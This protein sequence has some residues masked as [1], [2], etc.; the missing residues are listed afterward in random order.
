MKKIALLRVVFAGALFLVA[1]SA[2]A[3]MAMKSE[4]GWFDFE[5]CAFCKN[6]AAHEGL[7]E[8]ATWENHAIRDGLMNIMTIPAEYEGAM[9]EVNAAM[10]KLGGEIQTGKVNPMTL[11]MCGHCQKYGMLMMTG[12]VDMETVEGDAA[13]VTLM[14]SADEHTAEELRQMA[15][16][17][18]EEMAKL[19]AHAH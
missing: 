2:L 18:T 15:V 11:T 7:L 16:R 19:T 1:S 3:G 6:L 4:S 9:D 10:A 14:T 12:K 8:H 5:N 17:D 13:T